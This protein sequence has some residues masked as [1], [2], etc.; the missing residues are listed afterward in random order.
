MSGRR[1]RVEEAMREALAEM[2]QREVKDPRVS[3]AGLV[4][5]TRVELN[6]DLSVARVYV[7][8]FGQDPEKTLT[9]LGAAAGFLRGPL[10]RRLRLQKPPELRFFHDDS[11]GV[12]RK[13]TDIVREDEAKARAAGR[14][15]AEA[16]AATDSETE[17]E[18][19]TDSDSDTD[20]ETET[21][22]DPE[23][24]TDSDSNSRAAASA[25]NGVAA[26]ARDDDAEEPPPP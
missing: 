19:E 8:V 21:E 11:A 17:T 6:V 20:P 10:G 4:G 13:L 9:G 22:T 7:S 24:E 16:K 2:I 14:A 1:P 25:Q 5:V 3:G 23:T 12:A 18:T 15:E 26:A